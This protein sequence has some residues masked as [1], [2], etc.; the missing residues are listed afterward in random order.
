MVANSTSFLFVPGDRIERFDKAI[1]SGADKM[2]IDW[3]ASVSPEHKEQAR[4]N[5]MRWLNAR[6][7]I[8]NVFVRLNPTD[9]VWFE[10]DIRMMIDLLQES[11]L[12][13]MLTMV[14]TAVIAAESISALP[15]GIPV[16][17]MIETAEGIMNVHTI[18][19]V[20]GI[21]RLAFG[22]MDYQTDLDLPD[23][24]PAMIYPSSM[25]AI[26]SRWARLPPPIAGVTADFADP[27][28]VARNAR[29]E[30]S[31]GFGAK[32]CIHPNQISTV[33]S[34]F[35]PTAEEI[36]WAKA[37]LRATTKYHAVQLDGK[38]VDRP[39]IRKAERILERIVPRV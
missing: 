20:N 14:N 18:A 12:G 36:D 10:D 34:I 35:S 25:I 11:K 29:F 27:R 6:R 4:A 7:D 39:V 28:V 30:K 24:E 2:I 32:L 33:N 9:S 3:E 13:V 1:A 26:A 16:I 23:D 8:D 22:N 31:L 15:Q 38:M 17:C 21:S 5:T 19:K 37:V